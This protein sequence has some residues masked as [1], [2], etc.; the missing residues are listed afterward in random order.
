MVN[1]V[2]SQTA[3][4]PP[5]SYYWWLWLLNALFV[6]AG[7]LLF[8]AAQY[9]TA[10]FF[11]AACLMALLPFIPAIVLVG[12]AGSTIFVL[13]K[14]MVEKHSLPAS[15]ALLLLVGPGLFVLLL[16]VLLTAR[17]S[18]DR[19]LAY[20]CHGNAPASASQ[21]HVVGYTTFLS[22]QWLAEFHV[23][24]REFPTFLNQAE[25]VPVDAFEFKQALDTSDLKSTRLFRQSPPSTDHPCFKRVFKPGEEH[26]R[27]S[28]FATY[29]PDTSTAIV[30][31]EY[32]D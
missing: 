23:N 16:L 7:L 28:I 29:D 22:E 6:S 21:V 15:S 5:P 32:R 1:P 27:G 25:L 20:I 17:Q 24:P 14:V 18:P 31:R 10:D 11:G 13:T 9:G 26:E 30:L 19:W 4:R 12:G 8:L 2:A 3:F